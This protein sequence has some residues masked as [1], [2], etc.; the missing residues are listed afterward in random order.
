MIMIRMGLTD[1]AVIVKGYGAGFTQPADDI[2]YYD[3]VS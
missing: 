2:R 3:S 1:I